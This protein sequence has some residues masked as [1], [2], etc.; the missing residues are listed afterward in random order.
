MRITQLR[1]ATLKLEIGGV[2]LLVDP[3]LAEAEAYPGF[4]GSADSHRRNPTVPLGR[5]LAEAL[6]VDAVIVTHLHLDHW[7]DAAKREI[8][9][10][11]PVFAQNEA[12]AGR[13]RADGFEDVRVLAEGTVFEGVSLTPTAGR[14]GTEAAYGVIGDR[15]G[16]VSGVVVR[17]EGEP[18]LYVAGDTI[19]NDFRR[20][21]AGGASPG[22]WL[23]LSC[24]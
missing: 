2:R 19:W 3:M 9:K 1:N 17:A 15:L 24:A 4:P 8:P 20:R 10:A 22:P 21:R 18:T 16:A 23:V 14:H 12:D 7:D 11:L 13:I 6:D 5:P